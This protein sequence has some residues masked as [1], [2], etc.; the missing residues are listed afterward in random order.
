[1]ATIDGTFYISIST[2]L[3]DSGS[4]REVELLRENIENII[5][6]DRAPS[7]INSAMD[8][9]LSLDSSFNKLLAKLYRER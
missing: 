3:K 5:V 6:K 7:H 2:Y 9:Y 8:V 1:M 4:K